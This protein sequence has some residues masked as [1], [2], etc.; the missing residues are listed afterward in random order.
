MRNVLRS[1]GLC[2]LVAAGLVPAGLAHAGGDFYLPPGDLP[3]GS[4]EGA[5]EMTVFAPGMRF[6]IEDGP[7]YPNSQVYGHG[8]SQGP[9]GG[10]CDAANYSYPWR[11]NYCEIRSWDMPLC[12]A[13]TGHQGQDIRPGTCDNLAHAI[14]SSEAGTVTNIGSYSVYVTKADGQRFD[15]L[16]GGQIAVGSGQVLA[17][18]DHI[19]QVSNEFGGTAT[20]IHL[21]FNI[22][23]DVAGV[24]FV[25][26]SPYMSLVRA[27]E[28][29]MG[30]GTELPAG[31]VDAVDCT[32]IRGWAQDPDTPEAP[33]EVRVYFD[34]D[35]DD[36]DAVGVTLLADEN[37]P[38]LCD[39]LGSC[40]H[41]FTL[42]L[43]RS[44]RD[45]QPHS[46]LVVAVDTD[47]E[48]TAVLESS[49]GSFACPPEPVPPGIR[50]R[51]SSPEVLAEWGL[52]PFWDLSRISDG[53]LATID[54]GPDLPDER[55][56]VRGDG[57]DDTWWVIEDGLRRRVADAAVAEAWGISE[58]DLMPW[59]QSSLEGVPEGTPLPPEPY[60]VAA[61]DDVLWVIDDAQCGSD[62][63]G[64]AAGE[65]G[66]DGTAGDGGDDDDGGGD[67][68][69]AGTG[70]TEGSDGLG[71]PGAGDD[72]GGCGCHTGDRERGLPWSWAL[73][74]LGAG[75]ARRRLPSRRA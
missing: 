74:V 14:V 22:K 55:L 47:G 27:Y 12:P 17:K 53:E 69:G 13:G 59:P 58:S 11:D 2:M 75:L 8:G 68:A 35:A 9:G 63:P 45:E 64:C 16:H 40:D 57:A 54:V 28:E 26:V 65:D 67:D 51:I 49:P 61:A 5:A 18:G 62:D 7:A 41:G 42:G 19:G 30:L 73:F 3:P 71:A 46:V 6:P 24:G 56:V 44:L 21:H 66:G 72:G 50:R 39:A 43:P 48:E 38:D 31:P 60:L 37:R 20:T 33:V 34:G 4:G 32:S 25:Y 52:S 10:Q 70:A 23:Q 15:Y 29:L 1:L 36:P